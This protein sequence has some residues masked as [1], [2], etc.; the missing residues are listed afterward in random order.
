[1]R[2]LSGLF[3]ILG[4]LLLVPGAFAVQPDEMLS[5]PA[6]EARA[7]ALSAEI[8]CLVCQN[9]SIDDSD[10]SLARDLRLLVRDQ[11]EAGRSDQQIRDF[12][13]ER[14]GAFVL[15]DPP[16]QTTTLLLWFGPLIVLLSGAI[17]L[18]VYF[19]SRT[20]SAPDADTLTAEEAAR[21]ERLLTD[22]DNDPDRRT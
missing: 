6:Q 4:A 14:Y 3:A 17:G 11:I 21:I 8:R 9:Q 16:V 13:V 5:D 12:L 2:R 18:L 20:R 10:A 7:R 19:R 15:L 22:V 1:M